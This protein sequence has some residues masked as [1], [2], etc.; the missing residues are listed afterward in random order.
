MDV[1]LKTFLADNP[2]F[3]CYLFYTAILTLKMMFMSL[4]TIRQRVMN[5]SFVSEED[6]MYLKGMVSR[7]NE[8]V[9]RVRRGHRNDMEN[10]YL[11]FIIGFAYIWTDPSP[12]WAN[13]LFLV[14][15]VTRIVHT[16]V[17]TV[18]IMPQPIRGRAWLIGFLIT[19]Y[20]AVRTLLHFC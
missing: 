8:Q 4:L 11:F 15:T 6:A 7:T 5:N 9:E 12:F 3:R 16:C 17:Y 1:Q 19:G 20:M 18:V 2:V 10:I 13:L 14:F